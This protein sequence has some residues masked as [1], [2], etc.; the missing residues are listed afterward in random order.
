LL[1]AQLE[2]R[3]LLLPPRPLVPSLAGDNGD[4]L[5]CAWFG[6]PGMPKAEEWWIRDKLVF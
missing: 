3:R 2:A 4:A 1:L 5:C 6:H